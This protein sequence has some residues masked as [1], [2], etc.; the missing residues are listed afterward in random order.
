MDHYDEPGHINVGTGEDLAI[1]DLA[2]MLRDIVHP[3]AE[4]VFDTSK[5]DGM[6]RK[7]LDVSRLHALGWRHRIVLPEGLEETYRWFRRSEVRTSST[8]GTAAI[9]GRYAVGRPGV[10]WL[11][12]RGRRRRRC[13]A[14]RRG[15]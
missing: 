12:G 3:G 15:P 6:P 14:R 7:V 5:P 13:R 8:S 2:E 10:G 1:R 11:T 9:S 4:L